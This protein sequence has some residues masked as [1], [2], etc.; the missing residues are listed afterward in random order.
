MLIM[1]FTVACACGHS[2]VWLSAEVIGIP[3]LTQVSCIVPVTHNCC[4]QWNVLCHFV[5]L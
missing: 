4:G 2:H 5:V 3:N 1:S